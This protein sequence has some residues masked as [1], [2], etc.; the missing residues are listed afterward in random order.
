MSAPLDALAAAGAAL[1]ADAFAGYHERFYALT[2]RVAGRFA[3]RDWR[4]I[5]ADAA[6][7]VDL[8]AAAVDEA[9]A[10][11]RA[12]L[13]P[14]AGDQALWLA[15][16]ERYAAQIAGRPDHEQAATFFNSMTRRLLVT[17]GVNQE[18]EFV[19][20]GGHPGIAAESIFRVYERAGSTAET[21]G[22][23]L[24]DLAPALAW[25]DRAG[26]VALAAA[27]IDEQLAEHGG[28]PA[29]GRI[30]AVAALFY[31]NKGAYLVARIAGG[32]EPVPL[33]LALLHPPE[34]L[35]IDAA[36]TTA[37]EVSVLFSFTRSAFHAAEPRSAG[38]VAFLAT[39][40]PRKPPAELY[41]ALGFHKHAKTVLYCDL[42]RHLRGSRDRFV[43]APGERGMV[44]IV[45]TLPSYNVVFKLIK[46]QF[47]PPKDTTHKA[48]MAKYLLVF[49]HDRA[50]RLVDAQEF[51]HL[52][53]E[54]GRFEPALLDELLR[55]A[56][57]AA[58]V[59]GDDVIIKHAY[60]ER[61]VT[62]L[63]VY[64]REVGE[65]E[66]RAA[67]LDFGRAIR[68]LAAS[69][70][71]PGDMLLKNFGVTRNRRV[72]FYDYDELMLLTDCIFKA[73]PAPSSYDEE[74][75]AEPWFA[76]GENDVFPEEFGHFLGLRAP[77]RQL[78]MEQHGELLTVAF[79]RGIQARLRAGE[80]PDI[81][82]YAGERRLRQP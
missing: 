15:M 58:Q 42:M 11:L 30:E 72:A 68:D 64:L 17:I 50:G 39:L 14:A 81:I 18:L 32:A 66:A 43:I 38:L 46:D 47:A 24:D 25:A 78:F 35:R 82:P 8:Y 31:R 2:E 70:I 27:A 7:R 69:N 80:V 4:G 40:M 37:I 6:A 33:V 21:L 55:V 49:R 56:G 48:V 71:F 22:R 59:E 19:L 45:F 52:R 29:N 41:S 53:F 1:L 51:E 13:G 23:L 44:M 76:V 61:R 26:D 16:K 63:D 77:L 54:R 5:Q 79:W 9:E 73:M 12:L 3:E 60:V 28:W 57:K 65:E 67:A 20:G 62:P 75:A 34:G 74:M 10:G 36:L